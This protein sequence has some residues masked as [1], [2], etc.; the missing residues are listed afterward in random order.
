MAIREGQAVRTGALCTGLPF[1]LT[2]EVHTAVTKISSLLS[3]IR[4]IILHKR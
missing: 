1:L 3:S 2:S 4:Q